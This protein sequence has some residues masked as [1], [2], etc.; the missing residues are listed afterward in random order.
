[1]HPAK[2][3]KAFS[4]IAIVF[5]PNSTGSSKGMA[6]D[7]KQQL[8]KQIPNQQI[9]LIE[10]KYAGHAEKIA[11]TLSMSSR[12][13]LIIS[14]S[15]DGGYHEVI[16]GIMKAQPKGANAISGLLPAGNANDHFHDVHDKDVVQSIIE[17]DIQ[18]I[19]LLKITTTISGKKYERYA[20]S[21]IGFGL[22][23]IVGKEL[24]RTKLNRFNEIIIVVRTLFSLRSIKILSNNKTH[25]YYSLIFSNVGKMSKVLSIA[26]DA[27]TSDGKYE[28][29]IFKRYNKIKLI[30]ALLK[31]STVGLQG[32]SHDGPYTFKTTKPLLVQL[33]GEVTTIDAHADVIL[34]IERRALSC[35]V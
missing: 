23:P 33:D 7:L 9:K 19:D 14:A 22:T 24:N 18:H 15:G 28:V 11:F 27:S 10:T 16:N 26:K 32:V 20:H 1:M 31:A 6:Q 5:N 30:R 13:T 25:R 29:T 12:M 35:I 21:Y 8:T 3:K 34:D 2:Y 4:L 17:G